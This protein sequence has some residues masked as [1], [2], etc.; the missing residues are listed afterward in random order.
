MGSGGLVGKLTTREA[1]TA[2][3][4]LLTKP[5]LSILALLLFGQIAC[6]DEEVARSADAGA[7]AAVVVEAPP[8]D[9]STDAGVGHTAG[10]ANAAGERSKIPAGVFVAGSTPGDRGRDPVLEPALLDVRLDAFEIDRLPYPNDPT[11][12]PLTGVTRERARALCAQ[13]QGRL[14]NE[15]EWERACKGPAGTPYAGAN[16]WDAVC[17]RAPQT[18]ASGFG[19]LAMAGAIFG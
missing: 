9:E 17:S 12:P 19:T 8:V 4:L 18:C 14:C 1:Y 13:R 7:S 3:R 6:H 2:V 5:G 16:R 10:V 15:L 11:Q